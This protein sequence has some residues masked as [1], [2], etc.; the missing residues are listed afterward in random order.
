MNKTEFSQFREDFS[1]ISPKIGRSVQSLKFGV[2]PSHNDF[3]MLE[4]ARDNI[5]QICFSDLMSKKKFPRHFFEINTDGFLN[6][7]EMRTLQS[8]LLKKKL[9]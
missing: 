9:I 5:G 8:V 3:Y 6:G 4:M 1:Q 7:R 2:K